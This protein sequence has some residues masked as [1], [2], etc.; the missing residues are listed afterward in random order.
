M[1]ED[2][3]VNSKNQLDEKFSSIYQAYAH[4]VYRVCLYYVKDEHAAFELAQ[5]AFVKFYERYEDISETNVKAYLLTSVKNLA[6]NY[7]RDRK[8][9]MRRNEA[10]DEASKKEYATESLEEKYIE[11]E[12]RK[13][14]IAFGAQIFQDIQEK[15]SS[16]YEPLYLMLVDGKNYDE[17][18][19]ELGVS[20]ELLYSR[21]HR[22][23][24]WI[25]KKYGAEFKDIVA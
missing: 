14:R 6:Y 15:H 24:E 17:I 3:I 13:K 21:I 7:L 11:E 4:D 5:Q 22:A 23:K 1:Q 9:E 16:W 2:S 19:D 10:E 12:E 20:K 25:L 18:S 8:R